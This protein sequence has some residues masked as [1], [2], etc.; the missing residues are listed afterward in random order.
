[1]N[2][3]KKCYLDT[4]ASL[5]MKKKNLL[6]VGSVIE[7]LCSSSKEF[8]A[9]ILREISLMSILG[10]NARRTLFLAMCHL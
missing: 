1:M 6:L 4:A 10:T 3:L 2:E 9:V 8:N 7:S 5:Y